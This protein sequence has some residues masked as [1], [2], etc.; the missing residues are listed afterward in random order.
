MFWCFTAISLLLA[1]IFGYALPEWF[2]YHKSMENHRE[3]MKMPDETQ[4]IKTELSFK[5]PLT[6]GNEQI[7]TIA[8]KDENGRP[9]ADLETGHDR[10][11]HTVIIAEDLKT[12]SHIHPEDF[13]V[14]TLED[15]NKAEFKI[16]YNFPKAIR[17]LIA[18]NFRHQNHDIEK[19]FIVNVSGEKEKVLIEKNLSL[20]KKFGDYSVALETDP[21]QPL[22]GEEITLNYLM[23][24]SGV[25]VNDMEYYLDAP[26]HL[27]AVSAD[28]SAF[29]HT[30]GEVSQTFRALN[31]APSILL[32]P[33]QAHSLEEIKF[34]PEIKAHIVFPYPGLYKIFGEFKH[35][36]KVIVSD[37]M[38]EV[39]L[40][41]N[42]GIPAPTHH[43]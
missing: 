20:N 9:L 25:P 21:I 23:E 26:M 8:L 12:F 37:F 13:N 43:H 29:I 17:Y 38:V 19:Q 7:F 1:I 10:I 6:A 33:A 5:K 39:G 30:H 41:K 34:G 3:E 4:E 32:N 11:I 35:Q 31:V 24:K 18:V 36:N 2:V 16:K 40:G 22:S 28:L 15:I 27:S 14:V 42:T